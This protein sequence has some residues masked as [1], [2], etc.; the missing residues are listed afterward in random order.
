M[1]SILFPSLITTILFLAVILFVLF[2]VLLKKNRSGP[3]ES[4]TPFDYITGQ[5]DKEFH[6]ELEEEEDENE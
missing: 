6:E 5:T 3:G 4:Y 2:R 1:G